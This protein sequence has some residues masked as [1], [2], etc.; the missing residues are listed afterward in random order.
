MLKKKQNKLLVMKHSFFVGTSFD[1]EKKKLTMRY[2]KIQLFLIAFL[3]VS[4]TNAQSR[5]IEIGGYGELKVSPDQGVLNINIKAHEIEFGETVSSLTKKENHILKIIESLN[6]DAKDV[7]TFNFSV[8]ENTIWRKG[9]RYDSGFI[10]SQSMSIKF[11]N[12]KKN[13]AEIINGFNDK[14]TDAQIN[15]GFQLSEEL[16]IEKNE[17]LIALAVADAKMNADLLAKYSEVKITSVLKIEYHISENSSYPRNEIMADFNSPNMMKSANVS[18]G[19]NAQDI[20]LSD[21]VTVY[22]EIE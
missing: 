7:K 21:R 12:S 22:Y 17:T 14:K 5:R 8:R 10:A 4:F 1:H 19:F 3:L 2:Y 16:K 18:Q 20:T 13:I 6:Y 15:F 9:T 11:P